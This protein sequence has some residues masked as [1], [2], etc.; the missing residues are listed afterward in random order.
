[1]SGRRRD[2]GSPPSLPTSPTS[3][4]FD[5][6]DLSNNSTEALVAVCQESNI[7]VANP[8]IRQQL[9]T[10][11]ASRFEFVKII[12]R[13]PPESLLPTPSG[14]GR[15]PQMLPEPH[16]DT[17]GG[18]FEL[19]PLYPAQVDF[20]YPSEEEESDDSGS[21]W[22]WTGGFSFGFGPDSDEEASDDELTETHSETDEENGHEEELPQMQVALRGGA[23]TYLVG[24]DL[25]AQQIF[26]RLV[27]IAVN[28]IFLLVYFT[29][30]G[31]QAAV[32][33]DL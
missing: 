24:L 9:I 4:L 23:G 14:S 18:Y 26:F 16:S 8:I 5:W 21:D 11:I 20:L 3:E 27:M 31:S 17:N 32:G 22:N 30:N 12:S 6:G 19:E 15:N 29:E 28:L 1:M 33:L 7:P 2:L 25:G 10:K 13:D